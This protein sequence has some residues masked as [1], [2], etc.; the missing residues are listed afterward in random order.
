MEEQLNRE[1][2][3]G[4]CFEAKAARISGNEGR[5]AQG[6]GECQRRFACLLGVLLAL[7]RLVPEE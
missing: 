6:V 1:A 3:E 4:W 7:R 2:E 5:I